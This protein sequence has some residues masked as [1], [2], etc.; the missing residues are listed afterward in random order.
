L[1]A[2]GSARFAFAEFQAAHWL[3]KAAQALSIAPHL[4]NAL[5]RGEA[6]VIQSALNQRIE[7]VVIDEA[8]G[9]RTARLN[10]LNVTG[11]IGVLLRAKREGYQLAL[12][13]AISRMRAHNIW[14]S[15]RVIAFALAQAGETS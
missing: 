15:E 8:A 13:E 4:L 2:G 6:A 10:G 11:S 9:R 1:A 7:T 3:H 5:D 12:Q 14:L